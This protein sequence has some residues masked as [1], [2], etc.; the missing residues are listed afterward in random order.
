M[1]ESA[2]VS[3]GVDA[4]TE[5]IKVVILEENGTVLGSAVMDRRGYFQDRIQECFMSALADA[6][7]EE[8][9]LCGACATG[10]GASCV[11][12]PARV[13]GETASHALGA[14]LHYSDRM[15]LVD[16]GGRDPKVIH[17]NEHGLPTATHTLRRCAAGV[18]T[19]LNFASR[20]LDVHPARLQELAAVAEDPAY[21]TSYCSIFSG[22]DILSRLREGRTREEVARGCLES[23]AERIVEIGGFE[24]PVRV[25]GG[26][27][28][29]FPGILSSL[30]ARVQTD[31]EAVSGPI[32]VGAIGAALWVFRDDM[33]QKDQR[34]EQA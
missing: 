34:G 3:A 7:L 33:R 8:G 23:I 9:D 17:V 15:T 26:V 21:I 16:I 13:I 30:A 10:F 31:I 29:Y 4:G 14:F 2:R 1:V 22:T 19:F 27:A 28:E 18:G 24:E 20:Q 6:K 25:S 12:M 32:L 5:C 11:P